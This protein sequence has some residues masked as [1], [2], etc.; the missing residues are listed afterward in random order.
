MEV[1]SQA[2]NATPLL[3][4]FLTRLL[5]AAVHSVVVGDQTEG[6]EGEGEMYWTVLEGLLQRVK[7]DVALTN[8]VAK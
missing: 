1:L 3:R 6:Q 5:H 2:P 7:L 4:L 8:E